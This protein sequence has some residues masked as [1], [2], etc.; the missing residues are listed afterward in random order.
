M[1]GLERFKEVIVDFTGVEEVSQGF[2][3]EVVRV[4][5]SQHSET[6]VTPTGMTAPCGVYGSPRAPAFGWGKA[7]GNL[8]QGSRETSRPI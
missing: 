2:V 1:R 3:D 5:P 4:W 6:L 7:A 8:T